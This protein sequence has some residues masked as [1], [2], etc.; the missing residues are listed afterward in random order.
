MELSAAG[1]IHEPLAPALV[2]AME[3]HMPMLYHIVT[4]TFAPHSEEGSHHNW[5]NLLYHFF[6]TK[7]EVISSQVL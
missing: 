2:V 6:T 1:Q 5:D 3:E 4:G 7:D